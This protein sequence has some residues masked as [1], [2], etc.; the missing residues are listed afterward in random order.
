MKVMRIFCPNKV[1]TKYF[2]G[3]RTELIDVVCMIYLG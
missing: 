2:S 3:V 1:R